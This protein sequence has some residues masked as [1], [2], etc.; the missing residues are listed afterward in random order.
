LFPCVVIAVAH[1]Y[2]IRTARRTSH[3][4]QVITVASSSSSTEKENI[5]H[6]N[7][8]EGSPPNHMQTSIFVANYHRTNHGDWCIYFCPVLGS[9]LVMIPTATTLFSA[10]FVIY[11]E[12]MHQVACLHM[13]TGARRPLLNAIRRLHITSITVLKMS[14]A[15]QNAQMAFSLL[16]C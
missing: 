6:A 3:I 13:Q 7:Q 14:L 1:Y 8:H 11:Q 16:F 9:S 4:A 15:N 5:K 2:P 12:N 10:S